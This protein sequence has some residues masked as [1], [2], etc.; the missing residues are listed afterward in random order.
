MFGCIGC[1]GK[2]VVVTVWGSTA[3]TTGADLEAM[4]TPVVSISSVLVGDY[5]G[6]NHAT[7][8]M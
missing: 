3:E 4:T 7:D 6:A 1:S 8:A 2:S 5:N